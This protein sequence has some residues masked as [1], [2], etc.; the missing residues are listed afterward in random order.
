MRIPESTDSF[1]R[2]QRRDSSSA[3]PVAIVLTL[4][5]LLLIRT[6]MINLAVAETMGPSRTLRYFFGPAAFVVYVHNIVF[7]FVVWGCYSVA[8]YI[9]SIPFGGSGTLRETFVLAGWGFFPRIVTSLLDTGFLLVVIDQVP[10]PSFSTLPFEYLIQIQYHPLLSFPIAVS[11]I[12]T[13][14]AFPEL[15]WTYAVKHS[16]NLTTREALIVVSI[17][18]AISLLLNIEEF[19]SLLDTL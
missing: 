17:P 18:V 9:L 7:P 1:F 15:I 4:S 16:R 14:W 5:L 8:F 11:V 6:L 2:E 13:V 19:L 3:G 12:L 10:E